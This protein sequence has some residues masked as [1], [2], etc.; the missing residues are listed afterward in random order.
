MIV[1]A[2]SHIL[3]TQTHTNKLQFICRVQAEVFCSDDSQFYQLKCMSNSF[4]DQRDK[5]IGLVG[6]LAYFFFFFCSVSQHLIVLYRLAI[7]K[8]QIVASEFI[9]LFVF[10]DTAGNCLAATIDFIFGLEAVAIAV[11]IANEKEDEKNN[12]KPWLFVCLFVLFNFFIAWLPAC[13]PAGL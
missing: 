11:T 8:S 12:R 4:C 3:N 7:S 1:I 13:L 10:C 9:C 2:N 5:S 6:W